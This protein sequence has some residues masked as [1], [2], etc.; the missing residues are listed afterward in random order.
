M[1][2]LT[3][4][5]AR[6]RKRAHGGIRIRTHTDDND[7]ISNDEYMETRAQEYEEDILNAK[8]EYETEYQQVWVANRVQLLWAKRSVSNVRQF[9]GMHAHTLW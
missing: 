3:Y 9:T 6:N 7:W 2:T 4:T 5:H 8:Y 1:H